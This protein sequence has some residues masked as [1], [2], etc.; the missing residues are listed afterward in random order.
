M[1]KRTILMIAALL[2]IDPTLAAESHHKHVHASPYAGE[3]TRE[4]KALSQ[5]DVDE[6]LRGGGWGL[7][8]AA[9]L[10]GM[11]GPSHVLDMATE[12]GLSP[13]QN[14]KVA[15]VRDEMRA[16]ALTLGERF[17][18][19]EAE[20]EAKFRSGDIA[21]EELDRMVREIELTRAE[22]RVAHLAAHIEV[23]HILS[24]EQAAR[25][26]MLRGYR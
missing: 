4:I 23:S 8:K 7:A 24:K 19:K 11:P 15:R 21:R 9:E 13:G 20:L 3:E 10:N 14:S 1:L 16:S 17:V 22:L 5:E 26:G 6:L 25:Y 12:L 2:S 18:V